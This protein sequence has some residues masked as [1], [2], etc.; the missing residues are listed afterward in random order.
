LYDHSQQAAIKP[1]V[2]IPG[3]EGKREESDVGSN[4]NPPTGLPIQEDARLLNLQLY[5]PVDNT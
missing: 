4:I 3:D 2:D 1:Q 5:P